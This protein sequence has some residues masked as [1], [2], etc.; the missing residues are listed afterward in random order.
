[1]LTTSIPPPR[2][3]EHFRELVNVHDASNPR[4]YGEFFNSNSLPCEPCSYRILQGPI[5]FEQH[6][7]AAYNAFHVASEVET[8]L[9]SPFTPLQLEAN[10]R[11]RKL[12]RDRSPA[13]L[14][15]R[16]GANNARCV[17]KDEFIYLLDI[18]TVMF[19]PGTVSYEFEFKSL[20]KISE[21]GSTLVKEKTSLV[22]LHPI[23]TYMDILDV[24]DLPGNSVLNKRALSRLCVLLHEICHA[25]VF[26]YAC[27]QCPGSVPN[28]FWNLKGHGFAWQ[29]T[30]HA[31]EF[32]AQSTLGLPFDLH[33]FHSIKY[34][35]S[36][37]WCWPSREEVAR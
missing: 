13:S 35:W 12:S 5:V 22:Q 17:S 11:F 19:F 16:L 10:E 21:L 15:R 20:W 33:R 32:A 4:T 7:Q 6:N 27:R 18:L 23:A 9:R 30:S 34:N 36:S 28:V 14:F 25:F 37:L 31:V 29:R 1:M 3:I 8:F 2:D 24:P 26:T